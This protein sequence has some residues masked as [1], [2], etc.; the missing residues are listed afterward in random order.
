M[1]CSALF[2]NRNQKRCKC[3]RPY[4]D[5]KDYSQW[6]SRAWVW[7]VSRPAKKWSP[8][9]VKPE[10]NLAVVALAQESKNVQWLSSPQTDNRF[11][12]AFEVHSSTGGSNGKAPWKSPPSQS[13]WLGPDYS[14]ELSAVDSTNSFM[15]TSDWQTLFNS[16][17]EPVSQSD[18]QLD[19]TT[20]ML[21][22]QQPVSQSDTQLD[23][24]TLMLQIQC[25]ECVFICLNDCLAYLLC[26]VY[27]RDIN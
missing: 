9:P 12:R 20:L 1:Q 3:S 21:Q 18:T 27:F 17:A 22:I 6:R 8:P 13:S 19:T 25:Y 7:G 14:L 5:H 11:P 4:R 15:S 24:T 23:T 2:G 26:I 16:F 10:P